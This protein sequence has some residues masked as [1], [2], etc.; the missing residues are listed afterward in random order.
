M[1][2]R[3]SPSRSCLTRHG[4]GRPVVLYPR[5]MLAASVWVARLFVQLGPVCRAQALALWSCAAD[6]RDLVCDWLGTQRLHNLV[7]TAWPDHE[8]TLAAGHTVT[9]AARVDLLP[10][11]GARGQLLGALLF[12]G[13]RP[14]HGARRA[15]LDGLLAKLTLALAQPLPPPSPEVLMLPMERLDALGGDDET[16]RRFYQAL[17]A[18]H[19][20]NVA[21]GARAL[22]LPRQSLHNRLRRLHVKLAPE[23]PLRGLR[24][25]P[26]LPG[27]A[28]E[29]ERRACRQVLECCAGD[30]RLAAIALRLTPAALRAYLR[31]LAIELPLPSRRLP[32]RRQ[33]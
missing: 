3:V 19:G 31:W 32:R 25:R 11:R 13:E 22:G 6:R 23:R 29:L 16:A 30:A 10:V 24:K 9:L 21:R 28:L 33:A 20:G 18:R 8:E 15:L 2:A 5:S 14:A 7:H 1:G 17:L 12:A 26:A 4:G 27:E